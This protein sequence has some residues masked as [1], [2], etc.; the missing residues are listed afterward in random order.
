MSAI[1]EKALERAMIAYR[2]GEYDRAHAPGPLQDVSVS[3]RAAITAY[4]SAT[5]DAQAERV[6]VLEEAL[7]DAYRFI[8]K[9]RAMWN[10]TAEY[11]TR[12]YNALTTK[13]RA[14]LN[15]TGAA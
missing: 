1:D 9:P 6:R 8:S 7:E 4:L 15:A 5:K 3:V 14:A 10:F 11:D 2:T 12:N 13:I